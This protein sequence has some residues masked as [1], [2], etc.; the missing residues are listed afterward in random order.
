[1]LRNL[2]IYFSNERCILLDCSSQNPD[3]NTKLIC[4]WNITEHDFRWVFITRFLMQ[5]GVSTVTGYIY[6]IWNLAFAIPIWNILKINLVRWN[7]K[8]MAFKF[9]LGCRFLEYWLSDM[10]ELPDCWNAGRG[11][12]IMLLPMLFAAAIR[13]TR[14]EIG[15]KNPPM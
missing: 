7:G 9:P 13:Y 11:V 12:A 6:F 2:F 10:I 15:E 5:Q 3:M 4:L 8:I 1:M 14:N